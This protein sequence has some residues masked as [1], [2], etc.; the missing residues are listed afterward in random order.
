MVARDRDDGYLEFLEL[1]SSPL[2]LVSPTAVRQIAG[3]DEDLW[4]EPAPK[5][6]QRG[7]GLRELVS[8]EMKVRDVEEP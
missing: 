7:V 4:V 3:D 2:E 6:V 1:R 8:A 5:L